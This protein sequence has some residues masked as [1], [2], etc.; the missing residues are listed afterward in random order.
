MVS[1]LVD[2]NVVS[3]AVKPRANQNVVAW[4]TN[5]DE[6]RVF[7]SVITLAEVGRGVALMPEGPRRDRL[8][9]WLNTDLPSRFENRILDVDRRVAAAWATLMAR[10]QQHST[11]LGTMDAFL[12]ATAATH[13]LTLV[14]RNVHH[15]AN[16]G[17]PLLDPWQPPY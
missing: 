16:A 14:T 12:A 11:P 15:F 17:I 1:F 3:E 13:E 5:T 9:A 6:D 4:L 10:G 8:K 7:L 2:T